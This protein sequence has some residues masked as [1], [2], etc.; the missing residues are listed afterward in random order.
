VSPLSSSII[1]IVQQQSITYRFKLYIWGSARD[2]NMTYNTESTF[3]Y[4]SGGTQYIPIW[5]NKCTFES[6][7]NEEINVLLNSANC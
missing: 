7:G 5:G 4:S 3:T 6:S 1:N 2:I